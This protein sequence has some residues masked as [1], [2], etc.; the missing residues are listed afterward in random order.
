MQIVAHWTAFGNSDRQFPSL[1]LL[2]LTFLKGAVVVL[3][4]QPQTPPQQQLG[5]K[6]I[7]KA[8]SIAVFKTS[9]VR[10]TVSSSGTIY[11][12]RSLFFAVSSYRLINGQ[13][14]SWYEMENW[15]EQCIPH[16]PDERFHVFILSMTY[17]H[18]YLW[19]CTV[20]MRSVRKNVRCG[21]KPFNNEA[22]LAF[23]HIKG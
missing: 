5:G 1:C 13:N 14:R 10:S 6:I 8:A 2:V 4:T 3:S 7:I 21:G 9:A 19:Y 15:K 20:D 11:F 12:R 23:A 18:L 22:T 17:V 16:G